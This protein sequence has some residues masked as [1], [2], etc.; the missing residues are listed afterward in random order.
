[1]KHLCAA[2]VLVL[3]IFDLSNNTYLR[4]VSKVSKAIATLVVIYVMNSGTRRPEQ[5]VEDNTVQRISLCV[6]AV[7]LSG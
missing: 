1:M 6:V 2:L 4:L 7:Q 3:L 5:L